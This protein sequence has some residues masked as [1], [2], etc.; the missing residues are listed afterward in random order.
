LSGIEELYIIRSQALTKHSR[1][2]FADGSVKRRRRF[3]TIF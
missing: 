1:V 2:D 3:V